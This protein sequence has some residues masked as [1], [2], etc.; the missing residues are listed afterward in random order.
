MLE[1]HK[2]MLIPFGPSDDSTGRWRVWAVSPAAGASPKSKQRY[3]K[4]GE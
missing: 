4:I 2:A 1:K 3:F